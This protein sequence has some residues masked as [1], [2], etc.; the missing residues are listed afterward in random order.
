MTNRFGIIDLGSNSC[1]LYIMEQQGSKP[2]LVRRERRVVRLGSGSFGR[3]LLQ[4]EGMQRSAACLAEFAGILRSEHITRCGAY[5]TSAVRDA[6]NQDEF[7]SLV[8]ETSG[9]S[10]RVLSG[11]EEARAVYRGLQA[12]LPLTDDTDLFLDI[13]GGSTEVIC[14]DRHDIRYLKSFQTGAVRLYE[15]S[16]NDPG[17]VAPETYGELKRRAMQVLEEL[18]GFV[19]T[20]P[21]AVFYGTS[22]TVLNLCSATAYRLGK[23]PE[24]TPVTQA[25][26]LRRTIALLA[27]MTL[28]DKRQVPGL[29]PDRADIIIAGAA[30][31]DAVM[32]LSG[33]RSVVTT[34]FSI[35][36]GLAADML[37]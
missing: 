21:V 23:L 2:V 34:H 10:L 30:I 19:R 20:H 7:V 9:I 33:A 28:E 29:I 24:E 14:A 13:G 15:S 25:D 1:R 26:E 32:D 16:L 3:R 11:E 6:A 31:L 8:R 4:P 27:D 5:A 35:K 37:L 12:N 22:G 36:D 18:G 17:R